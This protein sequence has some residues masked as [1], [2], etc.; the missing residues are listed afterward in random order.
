MKILVTN[1]DGIDAHGIRVLVNILKNFGK[2]SVVAPDTEKSAV[3][4]GITMHSPLRVKEI[5]NYSKDVNAW[6][7]SGT[8]S[9]CVKIA[10]EN[11]LE[12]RPDVL[13]SGINNGGNLGTDVLYSGT[14]SAAIEGA[15][16]N[17]P[18]IA[19]SLVGLSGVEELKNMNYSS[20]EYFLPKIIDNIVKDKD[21]NKSLLNVNIPS[22]EEIKEIKEIKVTELGH[23]RYKNSF[24]KR[25]DP[26][27]RTYY[28]M[29]GELEKTKNG[30]NTDIITVQNKNISITPL[31]FDL[32]NYS[33]LYKKEKF[34]F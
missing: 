21:F 6:S 27:G 8:P 9:D 3:G 12:D 22:V 10:V 18:S 4:H 29:G 5:D 14:V 28:W 26:M 20:A 7:V 16:N 2:V 17:I 32:T 31:Q 19:V 23:I 1:D 33:L 11:I 24:I 13:F 25:I 30:E 34:S 15:I